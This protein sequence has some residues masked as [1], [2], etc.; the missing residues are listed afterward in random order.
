LFPKNAG[1]AGGLSGG[2]NYII[3]SLLSYGV[4]YFIPARDEENLAYS[5]LVLILLSALVMFF[6]YKINRKA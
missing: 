1:I 6:V 3:V 5:Y 2:V 4:V